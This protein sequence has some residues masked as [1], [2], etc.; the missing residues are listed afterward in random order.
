MRNLALLRR[1]HPCETGITNHDTLC[2][3]FAAINPELFGQAVR[4][5]GAIESRLHG[6][7]DLV[8][9]EDLARLRTG[10]APTSM[11]IVRHAALNLLSGAKLIASFKNHRKRAGWNNDDLE[12]VIGGTD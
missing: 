8:F 11:A 3:V 12:A 5:H 7:L 10:N 2:D 1:F 4:G 9:P 6:T